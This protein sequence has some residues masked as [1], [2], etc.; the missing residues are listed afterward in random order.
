[1]VQLSDLGE[2]VRNIKR[3]AFR[4]ETLSE[5]RS[6]SGAEGFQAF[7]EGRPQPPPSAYAIS[8]FQNVAETIAAGCSWRRVHVV[9]RP[10]SEYLQWEIL[11]YEENIAAGEDVRVADR[12]TVPV[13]LASLTQDFW[14]FD[15]EIVVVMNY[16]DEFRFVG[17]DIDE[18]V[19]PYL[20]IRDLAV[21]HSV[22]LHDYLPL[23]EGELRRG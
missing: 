18:N 19:A 7:Q 12:S 17:G 5:Y 15:E 13:E 4:L 23:V 21:A 6:A 11:A 10:L 1:M 20:E 22:P 14:M 16:N 8:W 2:L 3:S 9:S